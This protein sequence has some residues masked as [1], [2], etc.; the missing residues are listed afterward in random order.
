MEDGNSECENGGRKS[1]VGLG[2]L[3]GA[4]DQL[5]NLQSNFGSIIVA[6]GEKS[7]LPILYK[8]RVQH[9]LLL[10]CTLHLLIALMMLDQIEHLMCLIS[11]YL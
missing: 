3:E 11:V 5:S 10:Q 6:N 7:G 4:S 9:Y 2:C 8:R 1:W